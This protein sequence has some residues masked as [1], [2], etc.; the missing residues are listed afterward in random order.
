MFGFDCCAGGG[1]IAEAR[2]A[3]GLSKKQAAKLI[4][5]M[6]DGIPGGMDGRMKYKA[7]MSAYGNAVVPQQFYP[8]FRAIWI[9]EQQKGSYI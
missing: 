1:R 3:R 8:V 9:L 6:V 5:G 4:G 7:E 2:K